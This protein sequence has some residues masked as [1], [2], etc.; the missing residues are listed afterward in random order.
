MK[1]GH[2][3]AIFK[4]YRNIKFQENP[5]CGSR[6]VSMRKKGQTDRTK[7][8]VTFEILRTCLKTAHKLFTD[9]EMNPDMNATD[10]HARDFGVNDKLLLP[11]PQAF[12]Q[13]TRSLHATT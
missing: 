13:S 1:L 8:I 11:I 12:E 3:R 4:K 6:V 9:Q 2:S 5:Y 10:T 7:Q